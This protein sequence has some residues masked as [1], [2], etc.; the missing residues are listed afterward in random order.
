MILLWPK[1]RLHHPAKYSFLL[2]KKHPENVLFDSV[3]KITAS[4][5][6]EDDQ[7]PP[8][9]T[10]SPQKV[11]PQAASPS[12]HRSPIAGLA[13]RPQLAGA[14]VHAATDVRNATEGFGLA[15]GVGGGLTGRPVA[16]DLGLTDSQKEVFRERR[17]RWEDL[18]AD[19]RLKLVEFHDAIYEAAPLDEE[20]MFSAGRGRFAGQKSAETQTGEFREEQ[21]SQTDAITVRDHLLTGEAFRKIKLM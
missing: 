21:D 13:L 18:R 3:S 16:F 11:S 1:Y 20:Q 7:P 9:V 14:H 10:A 19:P 17:Q 15:G 12:A 8:S 5:Q 6:S 2:L 4:L